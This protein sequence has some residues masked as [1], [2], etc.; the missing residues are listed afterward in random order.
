MTLLIENIVTLS[1]IAE[2]FEVG[3]TAVHN[4]TVRHKDFPAPIKVVGQRTCLYDM[5]A[6]REWKALHPTAGVSGFRPG[7]TAY[8]NRRDRQ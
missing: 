7:N 6:V 2:E 5:A 3:K 1:E 8:R 4:W